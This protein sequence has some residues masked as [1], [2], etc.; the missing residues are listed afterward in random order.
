MTVVCLKGYV[1]PHGNI[2]STDV[3][4]KI[5]LCETWHGAEPDPSIFLEQTRKCPCHVPAKFPKEF[6]DGS[7]IWKTDP[8]CI[9]SQHPNT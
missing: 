7:K 6:N 3:A 9:A 4:K 2:R 1:L 8:A 5:A